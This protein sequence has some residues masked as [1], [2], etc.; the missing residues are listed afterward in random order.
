MN[1]KQ[2]VHWVV[3]EGMP[4]P[5]EPEQIGWRHWNAHQV[6]ENAVKD[7]RQLKLARVVECRVVW[8]SK[9]P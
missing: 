7:A 2:P 4:N 6:Y 9:V 1:T 8:T 3:E 5:R